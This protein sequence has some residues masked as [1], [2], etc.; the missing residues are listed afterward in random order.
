M[1][2]EL[3]WDDL[4]H[5]FWAPTILCSQLLALVWSGR[6]LGPR[7][8]QA[9]SHDHEIVRAQKKCPRPSQDTSEIKIK[10]KINQ[11][12]W[13]FGLP[14]SLSFVLGL[15]PRGGLWRQSKWPWNM[16]H[17]IPCMNPCRLYIHLAFTYSVGPSNVVWSELGPT[18]P[19][20]TM[21]MLEVLWSRALSLVCEVAVS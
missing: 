6:E 5:F 2:L 18:P 8:T 15:P 16:I 19:F 17:S 4:G 12:L 3:C 20:P 14:W 21:S 13:A 1:V 11:Q 7:Q 10:N 9:K